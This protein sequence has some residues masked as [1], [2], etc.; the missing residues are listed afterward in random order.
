M[1]TRMVVWEGVSQLDGKTPVVVLATG[2]PNR[3]GKRL[4]DNRKTGDMVQVWVLVDGMEPHTVKAEG[5]DT[6]ICGVCPH[7]SKA[8]GGSN[9]CYVFVAQGPLSLYRAHKRNGSDPFD[10]SRLEG[11]KVRFGA[12]GDPAA[13]PLE[14]WRSIASVASGVTGYTH[15][16]RDA[17][18]GFA[19]FCMASADSVEDRRQARLRGYRTFRVRTRLESRLPGEVSCPASA[20]S[21]HKTVCASCLQC[22]GTGNGR[23][24]DIT[25]IAHGASAGN[26]KALALTGNN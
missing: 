4:S 12:Y 11:L 16:W 26:F 19:E 8:A 15:Q 10:V 25:I 5:L 21:G 2:V 7:K 24:S 18:P 22:G 13:V 20:E 3:A 6:A 9:A 17:D 1:G 14:V 23:R